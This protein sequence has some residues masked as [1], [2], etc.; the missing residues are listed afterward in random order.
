[1]AFSD[2]NYVMCKQRPV[3]LC[4][5]LCVCAAVEQTRWFVCGI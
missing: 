5:H 4:G 3:T 1:M 2:G